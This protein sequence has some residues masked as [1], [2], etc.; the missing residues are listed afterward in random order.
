[1]TVIAPPGDAGATAT[2]SGFFTADISQNSALV[3]RRGVT[4]PPGCSGSVR[5][6]GVTRQTSPDRL[7]E[8]RYAEPLPGQ[9][10]RRRAAKGRQQVLGA[11]P[12]F[13][14]EAA[15]DSKRPPDVRI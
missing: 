2:R 7:P 13:A 3:G 4:I 14:G 12:C 11:G 15:H 5:T 6:S 10:G 8:H 9:S 1:M